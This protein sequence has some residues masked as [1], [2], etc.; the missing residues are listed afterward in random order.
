M[1]YRFTIT[2]VD[3]G[4]IMTVDAKDEDLTWDPDPQN[5]IAFTLGDVFSIIESLVNI[6]VVSK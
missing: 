6:G 2:Q 4:Y 5:Y 3:N 1:R